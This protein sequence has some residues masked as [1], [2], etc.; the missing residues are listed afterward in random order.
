MK[1]SE[2][3]G[4]EMPL[5]KIMKRLKAK[6]SKARNEVKNESSLA[7]VKNDVDDDI[8]KMV[9]EINSDSAVNPNKFESSNGHEYVGKGKSTTKH[10]KRKTDGSDTTDGP[11]PKKRRSS[12]QALKPSPASKN[13]KPNKKLKASVSNSTER[14]DD[15]NSAS[16]DKS[17]E[18]D[19]VSEDKLLNSCI[20]K[21]STP[22]AK[23]K[24]KVS[25]LDHEVDT[26]D[27]HKVKVSFFTSKT[28]CIAAINSCPQLNSPFLQKSKENIATDGTHISSDSKSGSMKKQKRKNISGLAKV[29]VFNI[30]YS[31]LMHL[32]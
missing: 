20:R 15:L 31:N 10:Q 6:G 32:F 23:R 27:Y 7:E 4:N 24:R 18:E 21:N 26:K 29:I 25:D 28:G 12:A 3:D 30:F 2:T 17:L 1:D 19:T 11:V 9:R 13:E 22:S 5:G 8:L 14:D 16:E